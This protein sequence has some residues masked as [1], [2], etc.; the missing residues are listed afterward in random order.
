MPVGPYDFS[1][2]MPD[3]G[4]AFMQAFQ[5]AQQQRAVQQ[6]Q[7]AKLAQEQAQ[8]Q[9]LA[10]WMQRLKDDRSP[11]TI[12]EFN[13]EFP[14]MAESV[15]KIFEPMDEAKKQTQL[16]FYNS[17]LSALDRGDKERAKE[18]VQ[19]RLAAARNT[20]GAEQEVKEL[21]YGL[22]AIDR[23]PDAL[24]STLAITSHRLDPDGYKTL[25]ATRGGEMTGFQK[26]LIAAG[27][28]PTSD[29]GRE[30]AKQFV[31]LKVDPIVQMPTPDGLQFIGRQSDYDKRYGST[32]AP[33]AK[34][35]S[36]M[37][38]AEYDALPSG[39]EY[40][41]PRDNKMKRKSGTPGKGGGVS[42]GTSGFRTEGN[43][44]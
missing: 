34:V 23:D 10:Q 40:F 41:D 44:R 20:I 11:E 38:K 37:T 16:G 22:S 26:D 28:D 17:A 39:A 1:L 3:P 2:N 15:G 9:R 27:V 18:I 4:Q 31:S 21:E 14:Q 24:R 33:P 19:S 43:P 5:Q 6:Q 25:Y 30:K 7:Q 13:L 12:T 32:G 8:R 42:N 35:P 29:E 36:P